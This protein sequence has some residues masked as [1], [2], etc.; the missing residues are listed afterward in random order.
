MNKL[1]NARSDAAFCKKT[2]PN[3]VREETQDCFP[4]FFRRSLS[5]G[6]AKGFFVEGKSISRPRFSASLQDFIAAP[7]N[8]P[9]RYFVY[10]GAAPYWAAQGESEKKPRG[11]S[12]GVLTRSFSGR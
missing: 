3:L 5:L 4:L 2:H 8:I 12:R 1:A 7:R 9:L 10:T 6:I 11:G